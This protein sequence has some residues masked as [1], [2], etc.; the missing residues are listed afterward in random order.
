[1]QLSYLNDDIQSWPDLT[2]AQQQRDGLVAIGGDLSVERLLAAYQRGI[3]PW[4]SDGQPICWWAL[5]PRMVLRPENLHIGRSLA[6]N[7]RNRRYAVTVNQQFQAVLSACANVPREGQDGT[8]L[9]AELQWALTQMFRQ[10]HAHSFEYWQ[11]S[12][13]DASQWQLMGGLYGIQIGRVFYG[14]SMFALTGDASKIAFVHAVK[15]L[16]SCGIE[17][18][19]CQMH[20]HHLA[21]FGAL[22]I[23]FADFQDALNLYCQQQLQ[24][25]MVAGV[26]VNQIN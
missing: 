7:V 18:I 11:Q 5:A 13:Q 26:L 20:T 2:I 4:Y 14:E 17:L 21:R 6:K 8:W 1:M 3:F 10:G 12:A 22:E 15:Y 23:E 19:D 16:Q 24:Q 25:E 9:T